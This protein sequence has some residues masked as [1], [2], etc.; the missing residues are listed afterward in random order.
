MGRLLT[1]GDLREIFLADVPQ[2]VKEPVERF[3]KSVP[4]VRAASSHP[5]KL[6]L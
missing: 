2:G 1:L 3:L 4:R 5:L 6:N